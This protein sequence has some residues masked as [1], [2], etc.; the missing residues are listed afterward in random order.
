MILFIFFLC[1]VIDDQ[2]GDISLHENHIFNLLNKTFEGRRIF[3]AYEIDVKN[4]NSTDK[5]GKLI[6]K[7]CK[8]VIDNEFLEGKHE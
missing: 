7:L 5:F 3:A 6:N 8:L 1:T 4:N 2:F